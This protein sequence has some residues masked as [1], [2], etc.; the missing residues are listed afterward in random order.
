MLI[1]ESA[2]SKKHSANT[3]KDDAPAGIL[4][5]LALAFPSWAGFLLAVYALFLA[6]SNVFRIGAR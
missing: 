5:Q 4:Y 1:W 2:P 3:L 6:K